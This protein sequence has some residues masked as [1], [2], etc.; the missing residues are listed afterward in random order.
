MRG[1]HNGRL[2]PVNFSQAP[3]VGVDPE[4]AQ[5]AYDRI[6][7]LTAKQAKKVTAE[8][9]AEDGSFPGGGVALV[10]EPRPTDQMVKFYEKG[11]RPLEFVPTRQWFIR[12]LEHK[13]AL[14]AQGEKIQW[15]PPYM[16]TRYD[17]WVEGLN[18]DWCISR[19][20]YFG[21]PF[22]VWYPVGDDGEPVFNRPIFASNDALPVDPQ[23]DC[24]PGYD[25]SQRNVPGGFTGDPDVMDTWATSS[26]TP[27]IQSHWGI[28]DERH[29]KLFPMD[30]RPQSHEIIR[31]W[32]FYTIVK[33][34]MHSN[35]VPWH[36]VVISG[37]I[38]DPD[39]KK[40]SKSK[41]NVVTPED[42]LDDWTA[43]GVRYWAS[44]ARLGTDT[45]YDPSVFK[46]GKRLVNKVFNA[47]RF[48]LMQLERAGEP[49]PGVTEISQPLDLALVDRL[50]TTIT[51]A[52]TA[53][54]AFDYA[55][56]LQVAE[57]GFWNFCDHYLELVKLR[58]Y[59][60]EDTP[61]RR[62]AMAA[63][64]WG[65][66]TF[67]RLLAPFLPYVTEEVWSWAF[68]EEQGRERSIHTAAWPV[69]DEVADVPRPDRDGVYDAAIE[70]LAAIRGAKTTAQK[71]L[72][73]PVARLEIL[74]PE[75]YRNALDL[76]LDDVLRA[77]HVDPE[78]VTVSDGPSPEGSSFTVTV[79]LAEE[80]PE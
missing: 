7:G 47:S 42:L 55:T 68:A 39:R 8:M 77:G 14:L 37:W 51:Q 28:D 19:Q 16:R 32:A 71:S 46:V 25:E 11:D 76:V 64:S 18:Q 20:R 1:S 56:A 61:E 65:L 57:D 12:I 72:R 9:L 50:R 43:D 80:Q 44:R 62:S 58:S 35:E 3:F 4:K 60:E 31:T 63:L 27:Q 73:W 70:L 40:M 33:A 41:G 36:H 29:A 67:L 17:H 48:V 54:E 30:V 38:L 6:A 59:S 74:G 2:I 45:A 34:W 66:K 5:A 21:V 22:P 13:D 52:T 53:F 15:H 69:I 26:L 49:F 10:G 78:A 75:D 24:P 79:E 23:Y